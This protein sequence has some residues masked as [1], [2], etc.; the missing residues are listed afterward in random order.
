[1]LGQALKDE[2][3]DFVH[4]EAF[5][6]RTGDDHGARYLLLPIGNLLADGGLVAEVYLVDDQQHRHIAIDHTLQHLP[7]L[8][9]LAHLGDQQEQVGVLQGGAHEA[10]HLLM[11]LVGGIDDAGGVGVDNLE[12]IS[13][14]DA[15]NAL[16]GGLRLGGDDTELFAHKGIHQRGF[17]Y[18]GISNDI[19]ESCF[20]HY[21]YVNCRKLT[22]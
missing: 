11:Q 10:H 5:G 2:V 20:M 4:V 14:D 9:G 15:H 3:E 17:P 13:V 16:A 22:R 7:V 18:V 1:M 8:E 21:F 19:Y 12:I 6:G